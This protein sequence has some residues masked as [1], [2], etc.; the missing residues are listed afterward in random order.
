MNDLH[1]EKEDKAGRK[2]SLAKLALCL[3]SVKG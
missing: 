2:T 1:I 3:G